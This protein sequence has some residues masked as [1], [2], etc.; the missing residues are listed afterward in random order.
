MDTLQDLYLC[1]DAG[2]TSVKVVVMNKRGETGTAEGGPCNLKSV[3]F[4]PALENMLRT[5]RQ[6]RENMLSSMQQ[7][8]CQEANADTAEVPQFKRV[9]L[10]VAGILRP[11]EIDLFRP[12]ASKAFGFECDDKRL[13]ITNDGHLL[14]A[15]AVSI[16][17]IES[18]IVHVA[19]T[20]SV[21]LAF[22]RICGE[23]E[24]VGVR[25]GWGYLI[26]D[27]GSASYVGKLA[28]RHLM[29]AADLEHSRTLSDPTTRPE[30]LLPLFEALLERLEVTDPAGMIDKLYSDHSSIPSPSN[31]STFS[32]A[33]TRRKLWISDACRVVFRYGFEDP[34]VDEQSRC[35]AL[36]ILEEA[37]EP[38]VEATL[39]LV[40]TAT[41]DTRA[42]MLSLGGG[43]WQSIAYQNLLIDSLRRQGIEFAQVAF[44][45]SAAEEGAKALL[46]LDTR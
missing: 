45:Q 32:A 40:S 11:S 2:G 22:K 5:T 15:P 19:G 29:R 33:E 18:T 12:L 36:S 23:L 34:D 28:I 17:S 20:G 4:E 30:P 31:L 13:R 14:A 25:G 3:G 8:R 44:V 27:E 7:L 38:L 42:S 41:L 46:A 1:V 43:L 26:G 35:T 10:G 39:E 37:I 24:L 6:A 21:S 16:P 9:W